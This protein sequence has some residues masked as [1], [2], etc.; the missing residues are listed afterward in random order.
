MLLINAIKLRKTVMINTKKKGG[1]RL[2][3]KSGRLKERKIVIV[4]FYL[5]NTL[6]DIVCGTFVQFHEYKFSRRD[7]L[8]KF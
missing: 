4:T 6:S 3:V 8:R 5:E 1:K 7:L 2:T